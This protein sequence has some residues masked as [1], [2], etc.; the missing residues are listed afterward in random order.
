MDSLYWIILIL[1]LPAFVTATTTTSSLPF[2][3]PFDGSSYN[4]EKLIVPNGEDG[5]AAVAMWKVNATTSKLTIAMATTQAFVALGL[6]P[7]TPT[8]AGADIVACHREGKKCGCNGHST[9]N[10]VARDYF[11]YGY[12]TPAED[13]VNDWKMLSS[14]ITAGGTTWCVIER[15]FLTC[16]VLEDF[17]I[18][19]LDASISGLIAFG[20]DPDRSELH[21]HGM[22]RKFT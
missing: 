5:S 22:N 12:G 10:V 3:L 17:Q 7:S 14:G 1:L 9:C 19:D 13:V 8:M 11:A 2:P 21:Y 16:K 6:N 20:T 4:K 15:P 18:F